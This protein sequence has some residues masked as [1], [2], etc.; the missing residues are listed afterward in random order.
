MIYEG[1]GCRRKRT[2]ECD[3]CEASPAFAEVLPMVEMAR[4]VPRDTPPGPPL[5]SP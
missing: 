2:W 5:D 3:C 1:G 4:Q